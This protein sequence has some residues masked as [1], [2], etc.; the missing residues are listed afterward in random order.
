M[1]D[2][3]GAADAGVAGDPLVA[4]RAAV[5]LVAELEVDAI[6]FERAADAGDDAE[7]DRVYAGPFLRDE[8][9]DW[10]IAQR[11]R[12]AQ[13]AETVLARLLASAP[14]PLAARRLLASDPTR[15]RR[16]AC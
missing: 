12:L 4:G 13:R 14:D 3:Q 8:Y 11:E 6:R 2:S 9:G 7:A 5:T 10:A 1:V 16:T 15:R